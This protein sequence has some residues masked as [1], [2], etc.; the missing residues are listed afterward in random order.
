M[1]AHT[2]ALF[3]A[4]DGLRSEEPAQVG[5]AGSLRPTLRLPGHPLL[6]VGLAGSLRPTLRLPGRRLLDVGRWLRLRKL[7]R[8]LPQ[9]PLRRCR[10]DL[11]ALTPPPVQ[12]RLAGRV[13]RLG[14]AA[15]AAEDQVRVDRERTAAPDLVHT[16]LM[17]AVEGRHVQEPPRELDQRPDPVIN[18]PQGLQDSLQ[19]LLRCGV[20]L[21]GQQGGGARAACEEGSDGLRLD[22]LGTDARHEHAH[23][24]QAPGVVGVALLH[25]FLGARRR[26]RR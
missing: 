10:L 22:T 14:E 20:R 9:R 6:D 16:L 23:G 5:L 19:L 12:V 26:R 4:R 21:R 13:R 18:Q 3:Q 24:Q 7:G 11:G 2:A 1:S 15:A 8:A 25:H 17:S